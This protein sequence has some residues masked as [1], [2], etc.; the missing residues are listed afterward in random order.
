[1]DFP[2]GGGNGEP[3]ERIRDW[4][5]RTS[6]TSSCP[7]RQ[8]RPSTASSS[9][10]ITGRSTRR[11]PSSCAGRR[12]GDHLHHRGHPGRRRRPGSHP[13]GAQ[14]HPSGGRGDR[15]VRH[16]NAGL[17]VVV[18]VVRQTRRD[19]APRRARPAARRDAVF[20]GAIG[21]P[22]VPD[23]VSLWGLLLPLRQGFDQY[24]NLRPIQL[25][26]GIQGPLRDRGARLTSTC[27]ASARTRRASTAASAVGS[28][29]EARRGQRSRP[30]C[31]RGSGTER[32]VRYAFEQAMERDAE[33]ASRHEVERPQPLDGLLGRGRRAR[34]PDYPDVVTTHLCMSMPW[35]PR[36]SPRPTARCGRRE[37][38]VRG[39]PDRPRRCARGF[40]GLPASANLNP[41][42]RYPSMF[43]PVHGVGT[44]HAGR[45]S[46]TPWRRSGPER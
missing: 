45:A 31:S 34:G 27:C 32:T 10:A 38:P 13:G 16:R 30:R 20:L 35:R 23:H 14:G 42:R 3:F 9:V 5:R 26:A 7:S 39:H 6:G 44:G 29:R 17:P 1:M 11:P 15:A 8:R 12:R 22:G 33:T 41:E 18:R 21:Y 4:S 19:D 28:S 37:Q 25:L 43:E 40:L 24:V 46:R 2:G 36:W